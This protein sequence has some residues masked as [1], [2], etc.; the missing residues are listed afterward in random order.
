MSL[1]NSSG[2]SS[3]M[4]AAVEGVGDVRRFPA[5]CGHQAPCEWLQSYGTERI[6]FVFHCNTYN[7]CLSVFVWWKAIA[8]FLISCFELGWPLEGD[9]LNN[10]NVDVFRLRKQML[11]KES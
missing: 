10:I 5:H 3:D 9:T 4:E 2:F 1:I 11:Q 7:W 6:T 8:G